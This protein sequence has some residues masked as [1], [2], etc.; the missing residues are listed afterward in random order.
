MG[1]ACVRACVHGY[2]GIVI[3]PLKDPLENA[4]VVAKA[5]PHEAPVRTLL[6]PVHVED[7]RQQ[8]LK[9]RLVST[10]L[11]QAQVQHRKH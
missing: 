6:E 8:R 9:E 11:V 3:R 1:C 10:D 5:G 7:L 2:L 4:D